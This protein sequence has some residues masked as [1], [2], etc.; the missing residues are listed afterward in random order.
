[1]IS[2][3]VQ[4]K[5]LYHFPIDKHCH[6]FELTYVNDDHFVRNTAVSL[7]S[8]IQCLKVLLSLF[9]KIE[10]ENG[11]YVKATTTRP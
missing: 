4:P 8:D 3:E 2:Y 5:Q 1:M 11:E 6:M 9:N 10:K 7:P